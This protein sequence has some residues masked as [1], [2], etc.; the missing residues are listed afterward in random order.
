MGHRNLQSDN[1]E[2]VSCFKK[3]D[4]DSRN[5]G[6]GTSSYNLGLPAGGIRRPHPRPDIG[7]TR[8]REPLVVIRHVSPPDPPGWDRIIELKNIDMEL[9]ILKTDS[10]Y[11]DKFIFH[12]EGGETIF[13]ER[14][15]RSQELSTRGQKVFTKKKFFL[16]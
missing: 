11:G 8:V 3:P 15:P 2:Y 12:P 14:R 4:D 13:S 6:A 7:W 5:G 1:Y 16:T 9:Q 10:D